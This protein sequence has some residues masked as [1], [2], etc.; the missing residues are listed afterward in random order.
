[1][2]RIVNSTYITLDGIIESPQDWPS[3]RHEDDGR[4]LETQSELRLR[5]DALLLGWRTYE[6][7][8]PVWTTMSGDHINAMGKWGRLEHAD[9]TD[10]E[11]LRRHRRRRGCGVAQDG[12]DIVRYG[13]G[14]VTAHG[15]AANFELTDATALASGN[16]VLT[17]GVTS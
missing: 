1:M 13:W 4:G 15:R 12:G 5:C 11:Q 8:V 7:F 17:Y 3:G 10:L 2:R 16:V 6:G 9:R 14:P